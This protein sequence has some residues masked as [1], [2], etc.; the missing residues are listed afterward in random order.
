MPIKDKYEPLGAH[1]RRLAADR[2]DISL[3]FAEIER[4]VGTRLPQGAQNSAFWLGVKG[5]APSRARAW[6]AAGFVA[7]PD[8]THGRIRFHRQQAAPSPRLSGAAPRQTVPQPSGRSAGRPGDR[9]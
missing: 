2:V 6:I 7:Q 8:V 5:K 3:T 4:I 9:R 1:M